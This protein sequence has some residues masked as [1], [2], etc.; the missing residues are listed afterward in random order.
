MGLIWENSF[1]VFFFL[2]GV[3]AGGISWM[4]GRAIASTW[5]PLWQMF[6]YSVLLAAATRFMHFAL[7]EGTLLS[8]QFLLV[9]WIVLA[10]IG[11]LGFRFTRARQMQLQY[12]WEWETSSPFSARRKS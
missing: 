5:R 6:A 10:I 12:S 1:W 9:D 11:F 3:V 2:T 7:F 8:F 4:T